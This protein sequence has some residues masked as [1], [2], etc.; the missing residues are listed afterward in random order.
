[1]VYTPPELRGEPLLR[2]SA[3]P[4]LE[5]DPV[6]ERL[7]FVQ[8]ALSD[9]F[10]MAE[11]CARHRVSRP[12]GYK[13]I[14]RYAEAGRR[15]LGDRG[16]APHTCPHKLSTSIPELLCTA[17]E[18]YPFWGARNLLAVLQTKQPRSTNGP[19]RAPWPICWRV[20]GWCSA[21]APA[22]RRS[23]LVSCWP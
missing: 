10:T 14:A 9:R 19:R 17:R 21:V 11:V 2:E 4:W 23:I 16:R 22:A 7:K 1:M 8:D 20:A 12:T 3:M 18:A 6:T 15:G 5:T 13:W